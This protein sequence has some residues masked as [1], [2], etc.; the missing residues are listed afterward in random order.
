MNK[1]QS[2]Q[3][4]GQ[5]APGPGQKH[6]GGYV[7]DLK[8][9]NSKQL[10]N[11]YVY[12]FLI[13]S[14]LPQTAQ[15][16]MKEAD[17]PKGPPTSKIVKRPPQKELLPLAISLDAPQGFLYEWWQI[18]WDVFNARTHRGG[19]DN[20]Q[21][22]YQLQLLRQHK[23]HA[24]HNSTTH[25]VQS[26]Q[27]GLNQMAYQQQQMFQ[28]QMPGQQQTGRQVGPSQQGTQLPPTQAPTP[29]PVLQAS[30]PTPQPQ[31]QH[32]PQQVAAQPQPQMMP[33]QFGPFQQF[34][35]P[36]MDAMVMSHQMPQQQQQ[37]QQQADGTFM[38]PQQ[39][40]H[41]SQQ[42]QEVQH[43]FQQ[44]QN[45]LFAGQKRGN[46]GPPMGVPPPTFAR[47]QQ[48][49]AQ[50][51]MNHLRQQ[52]QQQFAIQQQ[53][54]KAPLVRSYGPPTP[55]S[56]GPQQQQQQQLQQQQQRGMSS[57]VKRQKLDDLSS[58]SS[59]GDGLK[60]ESKIS[61]KDSN[62]SAALHDYQMQLL[63]LEREN[64]KM[65][66]EPKKEERK[67]EKKEEKKTT[68][69]MPPPK[70]TKGSTPKG[71]SP[72]TTST[73]VPATNGRKKSVSS[74]RKTKKGSAATTKSEPPTPTTPLTP[75]P[76][77][78]A[79]TT[80]T[81]KK[82]AHQLSKN[83]S[84]EDSTPSNGSQLTPPNSENA[85]N[86][87]GDV[88]LSNPE[89]AQGD[90]PNDISGSNVL[91]GHGPSLSGELY[92]DFTLSD[93]SNDISADGNFN[94]ETFLNT[95]GDMGNSFDSYWRDSVEA[96]E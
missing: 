80:I 81:I 94:L 85:I 22:Y 33:Q 40:M 78:G 15:S 87:S 26:H 77:A 96:T 29:Q 4:Q 60:E 75:N 35:Q 28:Q 88:M 93:F 12:D 83:D 20:A 46:N 92:P 36:G 90:F 56:N 25:A 55:L 59:P 69:K 66:N 53:G 57:P 74:K 42:Q 58:K 45:Q 73:S 68:K 17:V 50:M 39:P 72:S 24:L 34:P 61:E 44:Q 32:T 43:H 79:A 7:N 19:S 70:S 84:K 21:Q 82:E 38:V 89:D 52:Q 63:L 76:P 18:F 47:N 41:A 10:L 3:A 67:E 30:L 14:S 5:G 95:D 16:F 6:E 51:Q 23:E 9:T 27:F 91:H 64:K 48:T 49:Q 31:N 62:G 65:L 2:T 11:A 71:S 37:Q 13:K 8:S 54:F 86:S 1:Q